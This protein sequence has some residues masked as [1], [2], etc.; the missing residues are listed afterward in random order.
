MRARF[1]MIVIAMLL[2]FA[3][4]KLGDVT[5]GNNEAAVSFKAIEPP[6]SSIPR[7][8]GTTVVILVGMY[9]LLALASTPAGHRG[10]GNHIDDL[11]VKVRF[12]PESGGAAAAGTAYLRSLSNHRATM[13]SRVPLAVGQDL[14]LR[15]PGKKSGDVQTFHVRVVQCRAPRGDQTTF[16]V[17]MAL[18]HD[19]ADEAAVRAELAAL[20][21]SPA[22]LSV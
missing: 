4:V 5:Y 2:A 22:A 20:Q 14:T 9:F 11:F 15:V 18:G 1:I 10:S 8:A 17:R 21:R 6:E 7:W 13:I 16:V 19:R 12:V 3:S